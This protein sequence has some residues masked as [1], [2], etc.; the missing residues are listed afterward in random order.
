MKIGN[1]E[2]QWSGARGDVTVEQI[3]DFENMHKVVFPESYKSLVLKQNGGFP[4]KNLFVSAEGRESVF[5]SLINWDKS[6]KANIF[7]WTEIVNRTKVIPFGKDPFGNVICFN[8]NYGKN[9]EIQFWD[10]ETSELIPVAS[11]FEFFLEKLT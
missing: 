8:F 4:S 3:S 10:H 11:T 6:R 5:E 2:L 9:P 7:F 1:A